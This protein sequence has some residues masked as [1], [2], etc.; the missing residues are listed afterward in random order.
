MR[1]WI[2]EAA[3]QA[4]E[5]AN[6]MLVHVAAS[7]SVDQSTIYRFEKH[8]V[9]PDDIDLTVAAYADDL[10]IEPIQL[11]QTALD[12]WRESG[13]QANVT[14]IIERGDQTNAE[15]AAKAGQAATA[16]ARASRAPRAQS[17]RTPQPKQNP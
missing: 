17:S 7:A 8:E 14:Q 10:D 4:R 11:W 12:L 16:A 5:A 1:F 3:K 9:F 6:R 15:S 2:A 13:D